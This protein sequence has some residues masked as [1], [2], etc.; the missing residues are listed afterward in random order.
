VLG[1]LGAPFGLLTYIENRLIPMPHDLACVIRAI[2]VNLPL[3]NNHS[4]Y[5]GDP[6]CNLVRSLLLAVLNVSC[7]W[8]MQ[9]PIAMQDIAAAGGWLEGSTSHLRYCGE[10]DLLRSK[11][12]LD[13][14]STR[15]PE[16]TP[17]T[18]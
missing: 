18:L 9:R 3:S 8:D 2:L 7:R 6:P 1:V 14:N 11:S 16:E 15:S 17:N 5:Y 10:L 4:F 12:M 13:D